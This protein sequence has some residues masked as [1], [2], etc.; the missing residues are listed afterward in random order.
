MQD[1]ASKF[2]NLVFETFGHPSSESK[3]QEFGGDLVSITSQSEQDYVLSVIQ[4]NHYDYYWIGLNDLTQAGKY[5]WI[6]TDGST[7]GCEFCLK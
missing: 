4:R 1:S 6:K 7:G 5:E 3:C 2:R